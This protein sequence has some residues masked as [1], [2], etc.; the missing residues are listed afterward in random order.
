MPV[1]LQNYFEV[2]ADKL[3]GVN[4]KRPAANNQHIKGAFLWEQQTQEGTIIKYD[5]KVI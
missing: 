3:D 5:T 1:F 4:R 2:P